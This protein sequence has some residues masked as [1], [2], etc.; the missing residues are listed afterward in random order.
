MAGPGGARPGGVRPGLAGHGK[1]RQGF[2]MKFTISYRPGDARP[3][4][5]WRCG[6]PQGLAWRGMV[7]EASQGEDCFMN[8]KFSRARLGLV[9]PRHGVA[10]RGGAR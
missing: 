3:G 7:C 6:A 9:K 4:L 5:A 1:S 10:V 8:L 2:F